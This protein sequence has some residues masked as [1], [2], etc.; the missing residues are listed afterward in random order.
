ML[1]SERALAAADGVAASRMRSPLCILIAAR[2]IFLCL[3]A[4]AE[5]LRQTLCPL[6]S[7]VKSK[8]GILSVEHVS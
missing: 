5:L 3:G 6:D 2:G 1:M 4:A 7:P 8:A